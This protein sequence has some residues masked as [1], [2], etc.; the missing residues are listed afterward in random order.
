VTA[1]RLRA[2]EARFLFRITG[3]KAELLVVRFELVEEMSA[4]Y[5]LLV[6]LAS[7]EEVSID[8]ALGKEALLTIL[9]EGGE[10]YLHGVVDRFEHAGSRGR[11]GLFRARVVPALWWLSLERDCRIFQNTGVPDIVQ[12]ILKGSG[13]SADRFD[14]R[15]KENY[16]AAEYCVQYRETDLAFISRLLEEEGI[17][18]FFEHS[19]SKHLLVFGDG[20]VAYRP[21][22]GDARVTWN[23]VE[24]MVP[25]EEC[26]FRFSL[27]RRVRSGRVTRRDYNFE[28][29]GLDLTAGEQAKSFARREVYDYPGR[30]LDPDRGKRL[31][32]VRLEESMAYHETAEGEST[33]ARLV[34]GFK[35][36]LEDHD[37]SEYNREYLVTRLVTRGEQPQSLQEMAPAGAEAGW[38]N[39]FTAIPAAVPF[40]PP[41]VTPRPVVEGVQTATVVGPKGEEIYTDRYGRVKVQFHWDREGRRDEKSSCWIRVAT[42]FAGCQYGSIFIPRIGHE[43]VVQFLEGDPDRPLVIGSVYNAEQMPPYDLPAEKT[44]STTKTNSS[45]GGKGFNELRFEDKKGSEEIFLHGQKDWTIVIRHDKNQS[46]GHDETLEVG[47]DRTKRVGANQR[48]TIGENKTIAVVGNHQETIGGNMG[49]SVGGAKTESVALNSAE[50]VGGAKELAVGGAYAVAVGGAMNTAVGGALL[51]EVAGLK[52]VKVGKTMG[53]EVAG[54]RT[55]T[56]GKN[57]SKTVKEDCSLRAKRIVLQADEEIVIRTGSSTI[58]M[59]QNGEIVIKGKDAEVKGSG[60]IAIKAG[61]DVTI[62]GSKVKEN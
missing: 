47:N 10:R 61:G 33:C 60:K 31:A 14:F 17:F 51:E 22:E 58:S 37:R 34:P 26:V 20:P 48:E 41:R 43:V 56:V 57:F 28:K 12:E 15:L 42:P 54:N 39:R 24:G 6:D 36:T 30:Y 19:E 5:E 11:F 21:I 59:K 27:A 8:D 45:I 3:V 52:S 23:P 1:R 25:A 38:S 29:P 40:R 2:D 50:M 4:P 53:E 13:I 62:K 32:R 35:F 44:K 9:G 49:L 46:V 7:D 16:P 18:Y 55:S